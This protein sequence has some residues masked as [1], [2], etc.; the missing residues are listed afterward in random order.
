[1][2]NLYDIFEIIGTVAFSISGATTAIKKEMD[3]LGVIVLGMITAVGGG[4]LRDVIG[5]RTPSIFY[6]SD[7]IFLAFATSLVIFLIAY[8]SNVDFTEQKYFF[9][10]F[11]ISDSLGLAV[12]TIFG[13]QKMLCAYPSG[14][15]IF[16][17]VLTGVGGGLLRDILAGQKPYVLTKHFYASSC[18]LGA[19]FYMGIRSYASG[20]AVLA[21]VSSIFIL[22]LL[23]AKFKWNL[24]KV[25]QK[26]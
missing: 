17:G 15:V 24:P 26:N 3:L 11:T 7:I 4:I 10:I 13:C 16:F 14:A 2:T 12:F 18:I 25:Q 21:G 8:I 1:M 6:Q 23:A 19:L 20:F 22:R 5:N 9:L